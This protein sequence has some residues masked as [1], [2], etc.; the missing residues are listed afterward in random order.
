MKSRPVRHKAEPDNKGD[1]MRRY[2]I[3]LILAVALL[4]L[5]SFGCDKKAEVKTVEW[6]MAPEN[7]AAY[8]AKLAECRNNP[9]GLKDDPNCMNAMTAQHRLFA[10]KPGIPLRVDPHSSPKSPQK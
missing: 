1:I 4:S 5:A 6:Y 2:K 9:G 10:T 8:E 3:A 7:K